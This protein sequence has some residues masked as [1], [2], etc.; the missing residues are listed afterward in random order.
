MRNLIW[1]E[2]KEREVYVRYF[3]ILEGRRSSSESFQAVQSC[4]VAIWH[5]VIG[6][7]VRRY[8][9]PADLWWRGV[10][11]PISDKTHRDK[12]WYPQKVLF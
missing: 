10:H 7:I 4:M 5:M 11:L 9:M 8:F 12:R 6:E 2:V 3:G 1:N